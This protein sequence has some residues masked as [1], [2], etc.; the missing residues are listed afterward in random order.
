MLCLPPG[1]IVTSCH[2]RQL[3]DMILHAEDQLLFLHY[4]CTGCI[5]K[6]G[7]Q[8]DLKGSRVR[9]EAMVVLCQPLKTGEK[10]DD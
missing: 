8:R 9:K 1:H 7:E 3:W 4:S 5:Q 2:A 10:S 6:S